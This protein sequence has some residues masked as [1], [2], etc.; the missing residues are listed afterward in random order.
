MI[1][2]E[3]RRAP[4]PGCRNWQRRREAENEAAAGAEMAWHKHALASLKNSIFISRFCAFRQLRFLCGR[5]SKTG[6]MRLRNS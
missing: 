3:K 2:E 1:P 4:S 5:E 6:E